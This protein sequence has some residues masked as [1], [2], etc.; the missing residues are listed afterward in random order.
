MTPPHTTDDTQT[1]VLH[2]GTP[3]TVHYRQQYDMP[4]TVH[5]RY[6]RRYTDDTTDG[7][8]TIP[9]TVHRRLHDAATPLTVQITSK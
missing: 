1:A 4:P 7:T 3:S 8:Q 5:R 6:H 9:P 2:R